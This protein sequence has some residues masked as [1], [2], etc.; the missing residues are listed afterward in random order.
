MILLL[1]TLQ[2]GATSPLPRFAE[3]LWSTLGVHRCCSRMLFTRFR[4]REFLR[5]IHRARV[6]LFGDGA[7]CYEPLNFSSGSLGSVS[8]SGF[9]NGVLGAAHLLL[10]LLHYVFR[11]DRVDDCVLVRRQHCL[12]ARPSAVL[13]QP[14]YAFCIAPRL[15]MVFRRNCHRTDTLPGF[16]LYWTRS[17]SALRVPC[18]PACYLSLLYVWEERI[19]YAF[20]YT[21]AGTTCCILVS[22]LPILL[23]CI[24][25]ASSI[26]CFFS[27]L[28]CANL[29]F[30][31]YLLLLSLLCSLLPAPAAGS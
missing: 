8:P 9:C 27:T 28:A 26:L 21:G 23:L 18:L 5:V 4:L 7:W 13:V 31:P 25:F 20:S 22:M 11:G 2:L 16:S 3:L 24:G 12:L 29:T 14:P 30:L 19:L 1:S 6:W 10:P 15:R 17:T